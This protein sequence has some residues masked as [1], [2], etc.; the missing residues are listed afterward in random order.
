MSRQEV[1]LRF[2]L[3]RLVRS[4]R[5]FPTRTG[6]CSGSSWRPVL[7]LSTNW[8]RD[9]E[10]RHPT[11]PGHCGPWSD[12]AW[13]ILSKARIV[14]LYRTSITP[15]SNWKCLSKIDLPQQAEIAQSK[16]AA[17]IRR[18]QR[19]SIRH[20]LFTMNGVLRRSR[21]P[22]RANPSPAAGIF[23]NAAAACSNPTFATGF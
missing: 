3:N 6:I 23:V 7:N 1:S 4:P 10:E 5:C 22:Q 8:R 15:G 16:C 13:C 21:K 17:S 14:S 9:R 20:S 12:M 18:H 2:G 11:C 19:I